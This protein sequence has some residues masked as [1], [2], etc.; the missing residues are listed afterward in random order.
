LIGHGEGYQYTYQAVF[1]P[2]GVTPPGVPP[3]TGGTGISTEVIIAIVVVIV[4]VAVAAVAIVYMRRG[5]K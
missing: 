1:I 4:I 5:K 2:V 3:S